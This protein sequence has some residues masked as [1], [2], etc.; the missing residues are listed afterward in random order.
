M[1]GY[2]FGLDVCRQ[3][4]TLRMVPRLAEA[5]EASAALF[6]STLGRGID[7]NKMWRRLRWPANVG[8]GTYPRAEG[9]CAATP[10]KIRRGRMA[11]LRRAPEKQTDHRP[12]RSRKSL[13]S[14]S[15]S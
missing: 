12:N 5:A 7:E 4:A 9:A 3:S 13:R 10:A 6:D 14:R 1:L 11:H 2:R 8:C 15:S